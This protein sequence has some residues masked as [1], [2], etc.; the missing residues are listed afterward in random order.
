MLK[1]SVREQTHRTKTYTIHE[2]LGK[3]FEFIISLILMAVEQDPEF[4]TS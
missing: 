2:A 1:V 4:N 3:S